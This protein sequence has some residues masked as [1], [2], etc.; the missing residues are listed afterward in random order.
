MVTLRNLLLSDLGPLLVAIAVLAA[1]FSLWQPDS[2]ASFSNLRNISRQAGTL[3]VVSLGQMFPLLIGGLDISVGSLMGLA[4]TVG[5]LVMLQ[6]GLWPGIV[7]AIAVTT[8]GGF[9]NGVIVAKA[10]VSPF[11]VTLGMFSFARG[12]ALELTDGTSVIG[13]P[14]SFQWFGAR[15]WGV[16]PATVCIGAL[17]FI[18]VAFVLTRTRVGLNLYAI[19]GNEEATRLA[20]VKIDRYKILAYM[21]SA[22]LAGV[23]GLLL[24]SRVFSGQPSLGAGYELQSIAT[25][26]IGGVAIGGGRGRVRG[27]L[28]GV[29]LISV[30]STGMN[31]AGLSTFFQSMF[32]GVVIVVAAAWD[33]WRRS[34]EG[35]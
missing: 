24:S 22:A 11:I 34:R 9:V 28:L 1:G 25:A 16:F 19:G 5:A 17:V 13:L 10:H 7:A 27:V 29:V 23:G 12:L 6:Y 15:D 2:F 18:A 31:I 33:R 14:A 20:G 30:L 26:V 8:L 4:S 3:A 32:T 21:V 35:E